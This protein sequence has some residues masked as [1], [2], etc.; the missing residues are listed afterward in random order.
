[1]QPD[2]PTV[3]LTQNPDPTPPTENLREQSPAVRPA[4]P[5]PIIEP[6]LIDADQLAALLNI[7]PATLYRMKSRGR[8]PAPLRLSRGCVRWSL[9]EIRDWIA[10]GCP[11][12]KTWEAR[13]GINGRR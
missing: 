9:R 7:H 11:D 6:E 3:R 1:M 5:A 2:T 13:R 4:P 12:R 8:V 10:A